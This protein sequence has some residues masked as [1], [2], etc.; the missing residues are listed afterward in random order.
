V[1][2]LANDRVLDWAVAFLESFRR[3]NPELPLAAIPFADDTAALR[4][5]T[6]R[7]RFR[8]LDHPDLGR[9]DQL[10]RGFGDRLFANGRTHLIGTFRK[11]AAF[12]GEFEVFLFLDADVVVLDDLRPFLRAVAAGGQRLLYC[13]ADLDQVYRPGPFREEMVRAHGARGFNTGAWGSARNA[14]TVGDLEEVHR[15]A[16]RVQ[17]SFAPTSEQPFLNFCFDVLRLPYARYCD[18]VE[19]TAVLHWAGYPHYRCRGGRWEVSDPS[20][21]DYGKNVRLLH[22]AGTGMGWAAPYRELFLGYRLAGAP[23]PRRFLYRAWMFGRHAT[24]ATRA[25]LARVKRALLRRPA[26]PCPN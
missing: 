19:D 17:E 10:G 3:H 4:R 20:A 6:T 23:L 22:W 2:F 26:R 25:G 14:L 7:Y 18:V 24:G 13:D 1:Y 11:L 5:L 12:S 15:Q 16:L 9:L 21:P 8:V